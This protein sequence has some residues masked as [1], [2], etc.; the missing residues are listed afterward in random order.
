MNEN[1]SLT[2]TTQAFPM[3]REIITFERISFVGKMKAV[4]KR[5]KENSLQFARGLFIAHEALARLGGDRRSEDAEG[6]YSFR[7]FLAEIEVSPKT[8]YSYLRHYNPFED[9]LLTPE[10]LSLVPKK[11]GAEIPADLAA[12]K[13]EFE[14]MVAYAMETGVRLDGWTNEHER[15]LRVRSES[16]RVKELLEKWNTKKI[17]T[18]YKGPDRDYFGEAM[19]NARRYT[20]VLLPSKDLSVEQ[21]KVCEHI[22]DFLKAIDD[23]GTRM[24][25]AYGIGLRIRQ[26]INDLAAAEAELA[27]YDISS[28]ME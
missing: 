2:T 13:A 10:E 27:R 21:A 9:R 7:D 12:E 19:Q 5:Q 25:A 4:V 20:K 17:K 6:S 3:E 14:R 24:N 11:T 1:S 23:P 28:E 26:L 16:R 18:V 15:E 8:A 22:A